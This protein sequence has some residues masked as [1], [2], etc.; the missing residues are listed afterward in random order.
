MYTEN[1]FPKLFFSDNRRIYCFEKGSIYWPVFGQQHYHPLYHKQ[2][3]AISLS[4]RANRLSD[5]DLVNKELDY[6][7]YALP[8]NNNYYMRIYIP[9]Y[10][11][12]VR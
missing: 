5:N 9:I 2:S 12:I 6:Y 8:F 1:E 3:T 7:T 10:L 4:S 11:M